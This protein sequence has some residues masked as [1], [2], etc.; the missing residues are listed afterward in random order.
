MAVELVVLGG[1]CV[2]DDASP[3]ACSV[4][5]VVDNRMLRDELASMLSGQSDLE[6]VAVE[7]ID[8]A[9][10]K[11]AATTPDMALVDATLGERGSAR[12]I[13]GIKRAS[14]RTRIVVMDVP[15]ASEEIVALAEAGASGFIM[16]DA[17][18][19]VL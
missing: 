18:A 9:A 3:R 12:C 5:V 19:A 6:V 7:R 1:M 2:N 8:Q 4:L 16:R 14:P 13:A 11:A 17:T 10:P 15:P